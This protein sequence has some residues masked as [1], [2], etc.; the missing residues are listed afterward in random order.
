MKA[1]AKPNS[2]L[3]PTYPANTPMKKKQLT[4]EQFQQ[5]LIAT[6]NLPFIRQQRQ[7]TSYLSDVLETVLNFQNQALAAVLEAWWSFP[8]GTTSPP[9]CQASSMS[10][11]C[12]IILVRSLR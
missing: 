4:P 3:Q 12:C 11:H 6:A 5:L 8:I 7:P 1:N 10:A 9:F 2:P